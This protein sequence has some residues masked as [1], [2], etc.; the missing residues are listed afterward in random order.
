MRRAALL[1][2]GFRGIS[3]V[4]SHAARIRGRRGMPSYSTTA[5]TAC[6][7]ADSSLFPSAQTQQLAPEPS[8]SHN[9]DGKVY[10]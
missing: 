8:P 4:A 3:S 5:L 7:T 6:R 9:L 1:S 10:S 2:S